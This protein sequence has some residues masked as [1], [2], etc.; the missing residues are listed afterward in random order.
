MTLPGVV[1]DEE[2]AE[3]GVVGQPHRLRAG[4]GN[5]RRAEQ[6][7]RS[8]PA[9]AR[10]SRAAPSRDERQRAFDSST[11]TGTGTFFASNAIGF[12]YVKIGR[13]PPASNSRPAALLADRA[14]ERDV[15][16][17]ADV[18]TAGGPL[19]QH[20]DLLDAARLA[21]VALQEAGPREV[22][23]VIAGGADRGRHVVEPPRSGVGR[24]RA[25]SG[26][27]R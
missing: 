11:R 26:S 14:A 20:E 16:R 1:D 6:R 7:I 24:E 4:G 23:D 8:S 10:G 18:A 12:A 22:H 25:R 17:D 3:V 5:R 21:I 2:L 9:T 15:T 13:P 19:A 27:A